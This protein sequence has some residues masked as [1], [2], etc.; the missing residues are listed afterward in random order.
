M[1]GAD[2]EDDADDPTRLGDGDVAAEDEAHVE[3]ES[4][5]MGFVRDVESVVGA[6]FASLLPNFRAHDPAGD[7]PPPQGAMD[8]RAF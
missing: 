4:M 8:A 5:L 1:P 3:E 2:G 7:E 6:F